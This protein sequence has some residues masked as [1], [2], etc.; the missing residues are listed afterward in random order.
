MMDTSQNLSLDQMVPIG[1]SILRKKCTIKHLMLKRNSISESMEHHL[2]I[3]ISITQ[4]FMHSLKLM[5]E[6]SL[7]SITMTQQAQLANSI[8]IM[9]KMEP[10]L[11]SLSV[12]HG[13]AIIAHTLKRAGHT[14]MSQLMKK[15]TQL[16]SK[17]QMNKIGH[18][19]NMNKSSE[20]TIQILRLIAI[21][22]QMIMISMNTDIP[23]GIP[24][25]NLTMIALTAMNAILNFLKD[26]TVTKI[27]VS[28]KQASVKLIDLPSQKSQTF[29]DSNNAFTS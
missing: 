1:I 3:I 28:I 5:I 7:S 17:A 6:I 18:S 15:T 24:T 21:P 4:M 10:F 23:V 9:M 22:L 25:A 20:K 26:T 12:I 29:K 19:T 27:L 16:P 14:H 13:K 11:D 8:P 2:L